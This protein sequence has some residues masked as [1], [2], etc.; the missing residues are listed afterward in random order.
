MQNDSLSSFSTNTAR[1]LNV[2]RHDCHSLGMDGAEISVLKKTNQIGLGSF[3]KWENKQHSQQGHDSDT[4]RDNVVIIRK[5]TRA[6]VLFIVVGTETHLKGPNGRT[7]EPEISLEV[8]G[9]LAHQPLK[10]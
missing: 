9:N 2:L 1:Q 7:L 8:L 5:E 10:W 4:L 3:L 6:Q